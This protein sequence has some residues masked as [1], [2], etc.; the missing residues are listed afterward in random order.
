MSSNEYNQRLEVK[1]LYECGIRGIEKLSRMSDT[2]GATIFRVI[3]RI[4]CGETIERRPGSRPKPIHK[5]THRNCLSN[6]A[7]NSHQDL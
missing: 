2:S 6:L 3:R 7:N 5:S 1:I 4:K